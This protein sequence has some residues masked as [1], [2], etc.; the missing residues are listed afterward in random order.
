MATYESDDARA[1]RWLLTTSAT[2]AEQL[3]RLYPAEAAALTRA[4]E[5]AERALLRLQRPLAT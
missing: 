1:L 4:A 2:S 3:L 5:A